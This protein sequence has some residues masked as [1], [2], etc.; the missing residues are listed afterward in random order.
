MSGKVDLI[1]QT[2]TDIF[3]GMHEN[4]SKAMKEDI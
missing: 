4:L 2:Y 3:K 1:S